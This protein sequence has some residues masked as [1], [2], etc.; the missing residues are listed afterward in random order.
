NETQPIKENT[1][2]STFANPSSEALKLAGLPPDTRAW[3]VVEKVGGRGMKIGGAQMS[4]Q[5]C[6]FMLNTGDAS[7]KDLEMLGDEIKARALHDLG[8]ALKWEIKRIGEP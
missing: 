1:G 2:G 5:H 6:N 8:L 7:A 4:E 3:Q